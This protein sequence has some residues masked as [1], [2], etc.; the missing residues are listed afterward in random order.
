MA[1]TLSPLKITILLKRL[2]T[3]ISAPEGTWLTVW[4]GRNGDSVAMCWRA[5]LLPLLHKD[6]LND[7]SA[8]LAAYVHGLS[9]DLALIKESESRIA[10]DIT[11]I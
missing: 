5:Q 8:F 4:R 7:E 9:A 3:A 2:I 6:I 10:S 11:A 1:R